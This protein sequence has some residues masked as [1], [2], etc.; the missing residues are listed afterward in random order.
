V[1]KKGE[2]IFIV[3]A[4]ANRDPQQFARPNIFD[5]ARTN[6]QEHLTFGLGNH[7]CLAKNFSMTFATE[8]LSYFFK[9]YKNIKL[10]QKNIFYEPR[11][12]V[13]LPKNILISIS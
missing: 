11:I 1:I 9:R 6:K 2:T 10:L 12:N 7:A 13:R 4:S 8:V 3:L 5:I